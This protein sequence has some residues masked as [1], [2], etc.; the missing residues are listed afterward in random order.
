MGLLSKWKRKWHVKIKEKYPESIKMYQIYKLNNDQF[1]AEHKL[2]NLL[3]LNRLMSNE[4]KGKDLKSVSYPKNSFNPYI[5]S[6]NNST[7]SNK[8]NNSICSPQE[9]VESIL[10]YDVISFDIFDTC[11]LR[12]LDHATDLFKL[13]EKD[14][15]IPNFKDI[16]MQAEIIS[17]SNSKKSN[18][19][20]NIYDIYTQLSRM[21]PISPKDA[22][23]EVELEKRICYA[24]PYMLE[25]F[26]LLKEQDKKIIA[27]SDMYLPK[28]VITEILDKN[29]YIGFD[30]I[31]VSNEYQTNKQKGK[32]FKIAKK[33]Y[34]KQ[35]IIHVGDNYS[36]DVLGAKK[37]KIDSIYYS[38]NNTVQKQ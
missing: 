5:Q 23:K 26:K 4:R 37:A 2:Q 16:R 18:G 22:D 21:C 35:K 31:Y 20:I 19:E 8:E 32:L 15:N 1:S 36:A 24:N 13:L 17:R 14:F 33:N 28:N 29:G 27:I 10:K 6:S 25:V 9:F 3:F 11:I 7:I 30:D 34:K 38:T 12:P